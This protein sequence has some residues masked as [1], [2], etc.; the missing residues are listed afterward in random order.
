[1]IDLDFLASMGG[2]SPTKKV[3]Q[4]QKVAKTG[5]KVAEKKGEISTDPAVILSKLNNNEGQFI[6]A[7]NSYAMSNRQKEEDK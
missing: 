3:E 2:D 7:Y 1:M 5:N 4:P 6:S